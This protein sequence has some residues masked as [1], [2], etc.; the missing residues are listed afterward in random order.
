MDLAG[1]IEQ[2]WTGFRARLADH[3][4]AMGEDDITFIELQDVGQTDLLG[5]APYVQL[6]AWGDARV[7]LE[8]VSNHY[9]AEQWEL[10]DE[11]EQSLLDLG[12]LAPTHA[13]G[14]EADAGSANFWLDAGLREADRLAVMVVDTL[15][16]VYTVVH[17]SFLAAEGLEVDPAATPPAPPVPEEE[18][19][20]EVVVFPDSREEL[21]AAV[22]RALGVML[23]G[24]LRHDDDGDVP[25]IRGS[26]VVFVRVAADRPAV[27]LYSELVVGVDD[28]DRAA[29]EV[30]I[31][32][33]S[34]PIAKFVLR[35]QLV[36]LHYRIVAWPFAPSQLRVAVASLLEEVDELA[37]DLAARVGGLRF[38]ESLV[39]DAP[40]PPVATDGAH[41]DDAHPGLVALLELLHDEPVP[42][43]MVAALFDQSRSELVGQLVRLRTGRSSTGAFDPELV[44]GHLRAGLRHIVEREA[45]VGSGERRRRPRTRQ[46]SLLPER[47]ETLDAELWSPP[48][49]EESS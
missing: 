28:L 33:R 12:W 38:A 5:A 39:P 37:R 2:A 13:P 20:E 35:D 22:D 44:L 27:D 8:A 6:A 29:A 30:A 46:L 34:H 47:E 21:Q 3:I 42:P 31:L 18:S 32:N 11:A 26:S 23:E 36:S 43:R 15:R 10:T 9:L 41:V 19:D 48:G 1:E 49:L 14:D 17:P 45:G 40:T 25:I 16:R 7:R 24:P 4:A